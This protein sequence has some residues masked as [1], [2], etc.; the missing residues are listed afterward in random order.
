MFFTLA[1]FSEWVF[2]EASP[3]GT[4]S[5]KSN[6]RIFGCC[7]RRAM[8]IMVLLLGCIGCRH[9]I[10]PSLRTTQTGKVG[11][12][13]LFYHAMQLIQRADDTRKYLVYSVLKLQRH[14]NCSGLIEMDT[15]IGGK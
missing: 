5:E 14:Q 8:M 9:A 13:V 10:Q 4:N 1:H 11:M 3:P 12:A 7:S 6:I 2:F 15:P